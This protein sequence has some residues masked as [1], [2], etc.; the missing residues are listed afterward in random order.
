MPQC[1]ALRLGGT[2]VL[3]AGGTK[4]HG[5]KSLIGRECQKCMSM[6]RFTDHWEHWIEKDGLDILLQARVKYRWVGTRRE[7]GVFTWM[8]KQFGC[9]ARNREVRENFGKG[10][11]ECICRR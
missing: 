5:A 7:L 6:G 9:F 1:I 8:V 11:L 3:N 4:D 2:F 10:H